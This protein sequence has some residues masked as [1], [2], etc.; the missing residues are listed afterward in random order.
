MTKI[1]NLLFTLLLLA[2]MCAFSNSSNTS[3]K[4]PDI[5]KRSQSTEM[6]AYSCCNITISI[7]ITVP[8]YDLRNIDLSNI[9]I[10]NV[11]V[12]TLTIPEVNFVNLEIPNFDLSLNLPDFSNMNIDLILPELT[13]SDIS[14][15][16]FEFA[17]FSWDI[18]QDV[19]SLADKIGSISITFP[20]IQLLYFEVDLEGDI[21]NPGRVIESL[22]TEVDQAIH[23]TIKAT[24]DAVK[25][26]RNSIAMMQGVDIERVLKE[27]R[28]HINDCRENKS[29]VIALTKDL[30][31]IGAEISA[32][33]ENDPSLSSQEMQERALDKIKHIDYLQTGTVNGGLV[34]GSSLLS[35][36]I[37][38]SVSW[39]TSGGAYTLIAAMV[40]NVMMAQVTE[41]IEHEQ[42]K[43]KSC[44]E[45]Y[46]MAFEGYNNAYETLILAIE[47]DGIKANELLT[48]NSEVEKLTN[49]WI[50]LLLYTDESNTAQKVKG[51]EELKNSILLILST[52]RADYPDHSPV[53]MLETIN[54]IKEM[55]L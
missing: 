41:E 6:A 26:I 53:A 10:V 24:G 7:N 3:Y 50:D 39:A 11:T 25:T 44:G 40:I 52:F 22:K 55:E 46:A 29:F 21:K 16:E 23:D 37:N 42:D 28:T 54:K 12:P 51:F 13:I 33:S 17:H 34:I 45:E 9:N 2:P 15:P 14:I 30:S 47:S 27:I 5:N 4:R 43:L 32:E 8:S 48:I 1:I 19:Q 49:L 35:Y 18:G 20:E 31:K 38:N 36:G